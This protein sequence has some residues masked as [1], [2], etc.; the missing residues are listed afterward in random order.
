MPEIQTRE[1]SIHVTEN[2]EEQ[3]KEKQTKGCL[4]HLIDLLLYI[5]LK[6]FVVTFQVICEK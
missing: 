1:D 5:N 4:G 2:R 3:G 6:I